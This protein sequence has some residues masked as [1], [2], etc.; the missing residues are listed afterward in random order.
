MG[1]FE[2]T[3]SPQ[4]FAQAFPFHLVIDASLKI[5]Q[6]GD[7][8][9]RVLD[10]SLVGERIEDYFLI[11]RPKIDW[12]LA[13]IQQKQQSL[14][15]LSVKQSKIILK[16]Q[17]SWD[18]SQEVLF[19]LGSVWV[20]KADDLKEM[21]L[22]FQDFALHDTTSDFVILQ[23]T[24]QMALEDAQALT[25]EVQ[26]QKEQVENLLKQQEQLTNEAHKRAQM[27]EE[28]LGNLRQTQ[29]HLVQAEK[30]SALGQLTAGIA[31]EINNPLAFISGNLEILESD[32]AI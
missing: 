1:S 23:R 32:T 24:S 28:T 25:Q 22:K 9:Q 20:H 6:A 14:F 3:L 5:V 29:L 10:V 7:V 13:A 18:P 4:V 17:M 26:L 31:H 12:D 30:M 2:Y 15:V 19:F 16:G 11:S 21:G 8:I 27:L